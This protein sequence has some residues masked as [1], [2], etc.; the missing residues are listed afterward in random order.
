[1]NESPPRANDQKDAA[2]YFADQYKMDVSNA[3][4]LG[5]VTARNLNNAAATV[6][7]GR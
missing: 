5:E 3:S 6:A 4:D 1:M 2:A 7:Y